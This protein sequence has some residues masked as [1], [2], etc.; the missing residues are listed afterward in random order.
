M[1]VDEGETQPL[2]PPNV[3][4]VPSINEIAHQAVGLLHLIQ[5]EPTLPKE[6]CG[7]LEDEICAQ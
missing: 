1:E 7:V 6:P 4:S 5:P 2:D 3:D